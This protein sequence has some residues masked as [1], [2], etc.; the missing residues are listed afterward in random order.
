M[1]LA[2]RILL[3]AIVLGAPASGWAH[4]FPDH[5]EP[6][7]GHT[8]DESPSSVRIWFDGDIEPRFSQVRVASA[9]GQPVD[10]G[11]SQVDSQNRRL[12]HVGLVPLV[13]G[14]YRVT[15]SVL[16]VDGHRTDGDYSFTLKAPD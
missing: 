12:L 1:T 2:R 10:R 13:P 5:S 4:A 7:V 9:N 11:D 8:L 16:S 14:K 3:L 6:R 15:W